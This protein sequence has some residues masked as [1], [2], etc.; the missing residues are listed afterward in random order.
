MKASVSRAGSWSKARPR[1]HHPPG[2]PRTG[3]LVSVTF[4]R[5]ITP[6][7]CLQLC[8]LPPSGLPGGPSPGQELAATSPPCSGPTLFYRTPLLTPPHLPAPGAGGNRR[9]FSP[10]AGGGSSHPHE[11]STREGTCC[12]GNCLVCCHLICETDTELSSRLGS[13]S[14]RLSLEPTDPH[15]G[16]GA[17]GRGAAGGLIVQ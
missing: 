2:H 11:L 4:V 16:G 13:T 15:A 8:P 14:A 1:P 6:V 10:G 3:R 17:A 9:L 5:T 12:F 7:C